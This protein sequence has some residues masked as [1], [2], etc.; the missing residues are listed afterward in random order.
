MR[1]RL[2]LR[3]CFNTIMKN[4]FEKITIALAVIALLAFSIFS[5]SAVRTPPIFS[6][7]VEAS[8]SATAE[9]PTQ[10]PTQ[11][12]G[13]TEPPTETT[14]PSEDSGKIVDEHKNLISQ[15]FEFVNSQW[16]NVQ[17]LI[18]NFANDESTSLGFISEASRD[19][20]NT[21]SV[22]FRIVGYLLIILF[23][24]INLMETAL[25]YE[26][27]TYKGAV[28]IF[29]GILLAKVWVDMSVNICY[30][31]LKAVGDLTA[32]I[33]SPQT[34]ELLVPPSYD[35]PLSGIPIIGTIVD[36]YL[37]STN[38]IPLIITYLVI[39][40]VIVVITVKLTV[41]S[42]EITCL[43]T[44]SPLFFAAL[45]GEET[46]KYFQSFITAFLGVCLDILFIAVVVLVG[47]QCL[48]NMSS[49]DPNA[50]VWTFLTQNHQ[51]F[52]V[53]I[54][55]GVMAAKPPKVLKGLIG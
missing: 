55:I 36:L 3:Q 1:R 15:F 22:I 9:T 2:R 23:F 42:I 11:A 12:S 52:C 17:N 40:I 45:A 33:S 26:M 41:R 43:M 24:G 53:I 39:L 25:R 35:T 8:A 30:L 50:S 48:N 28:K 32:A 49:S 7:E 44:V 20:A 21:F 16:V 54:A 37:I 4:L 19:F 5:V 6:P 47:M 46:K 51:R 31:I 14:E 27:M 10:Q 38:F 34:N 29:G 13:Y 18:R